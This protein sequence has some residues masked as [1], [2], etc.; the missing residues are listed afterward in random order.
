MVISGDHTKTN[1]GLSLKFEAKAL[2]V[3]DYTR[4]DSRHWEYSIKAIELIKEYKVIGKTSDSISQL[5]S[6]I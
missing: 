3:I 2:K 6:E 1:L 4:K 5:T